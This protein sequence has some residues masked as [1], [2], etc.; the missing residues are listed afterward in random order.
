MCARRMAGTLA[1]LGASRPAYRVENWFAGASEAKSSSRC[2]F[3]PV[4]RSFRSVTSRKVGSDQVHC[5]VQH[6]HAP[7]SLEYLRIGYAIRMLKANFST[8]VFTTINYTIQMPGR[9]ARGTETQHRVSHARNA[10]ARKA[11]FAKQQQALQ[12]GQTCKVAHVVSSWNTAPHTT[13]GRWASA[14]AN[15]T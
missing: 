1:A 14:D 8:R 6:E 13:T 9:S 2:C 5:F 10:Y 3:S 11:S 15:P 7:W 12:R 4:P